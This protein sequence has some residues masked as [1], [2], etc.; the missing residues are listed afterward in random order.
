MPGSFEKGYA[1]FTSFFSAQQTSDGG[2]IVTGG[3][4]INP[5]IVLVKTDSIGDT[6]WAK[7]Y[8]EPRTF[9]T[10]HVQESPDCGFIITGYAHVFHLYK[11]EVLDIMGKTLEVIK[12]DQRQWNIDCIQLPSGIFILKIE[13][14]AGT[15]VKKIVKE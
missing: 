2:Y 14:E 7:K 13:T 6:L 9:W 8:N 11:I 10:V 15:V 5:G 3:S 12:N 1:D 4:Q